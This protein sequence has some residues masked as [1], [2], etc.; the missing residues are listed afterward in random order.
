MPV[1]ACS[2]E[3]SEIQVVGT[4]GIDIPFRPVVRHDCRSWRKHKSISSST[5]VIAPVITMITVDAGAERH[6]DIKLL[7]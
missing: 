2:P 5:F 3:L 7:R 6:V 1:G 4:I